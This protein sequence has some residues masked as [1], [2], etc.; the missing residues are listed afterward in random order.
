MGT[1]HTL[2]IRGQNRGINSSLGTP[3]YHYKKGGRSAKKGRDFG[4]GRTID[5]ILLRGENSEK[6]S[7][8]TSRYPRKKFTIVY[9]R[10]QKESNFASL[11]G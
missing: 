7:E 3:E 6:T 1:I 5:K 8:I 4:N 9:T 2:V 10:I 11:K